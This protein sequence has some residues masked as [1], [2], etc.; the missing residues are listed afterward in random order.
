MNS[1]S[2]QFAALSKLC[3]KA[4]L[5]DEGGQPLVFIP[6]LPVSSCG[7]VHVV[8]VLLAPGERDSY[9][10]RLFF[11]RQLPAARNW[12]CFSIKAGSWFAFSWQGVPANLTWDEILASHLE[13]VK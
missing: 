11:S 10:T 9:Q 1:H 5:W 13:A 7:A 4:E 2:A 6:G 12:S 3:P 8:D